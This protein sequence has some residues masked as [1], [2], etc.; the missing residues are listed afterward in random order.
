ML[1]NK[2]H[3]VNANP[4][5]PPFPENFEQA[6]FAMGCFWGA[7]RK[8]WQFPNVFSTAVGY[9]NGHTTD[10]VYKGVCSGLTGHNEV[11]LVIFDPAILEYK[12]LLQLFWESHNPTQ[13]MQQG[14][15][16]GSQYRSGIYTFNQEQFDQ[17]I[18]SKQHYQN[19]L[20][21]ADISK[22]RI[23]QYISKGIA[24]LVQRG[25]FRETRQRGE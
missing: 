18:V 19:R 10:P 12:Q 25:C 20:L 6:L 14:N 3:Y 7:E 5:S 16:I 22:Q 11:V 1:L 13:G 4:I 15:D 21:Q 24:F 9:S 8:F 2:H 23:A 17:A